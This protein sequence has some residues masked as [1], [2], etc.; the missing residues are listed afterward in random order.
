MQCTPKIKPKNRGQHCLAPVEEI[1]S[2][3][4][5]YKSHHSA[6]IRET[7][8]LAS[9]DEVLEGEIQDPGIGA[10]YSLLSLNQR[11]RNCTQS[12]TQFQG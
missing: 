10:K 12:E 8:Q 7:N 9:K 5:S 4:G 2:L 11:I 3:Y 1:R 6:V